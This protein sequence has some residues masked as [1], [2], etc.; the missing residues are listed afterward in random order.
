[1]SNDE[2]F[3]IVSG[4]YAPFLK[5]YETSNLGLKCERGIECEIVD[6]KLLSDGYEKIAILESDRSIELHAKYGKHFK[7]R[8]PTF[9]WALEYIPFN[10]DLAIV[11]ASNEMWWLNLD[12]G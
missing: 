12:R 1:M 11:G 10:G 4:V 2:Q 5:I 8:V 6:F 3:L 7:T 9:G